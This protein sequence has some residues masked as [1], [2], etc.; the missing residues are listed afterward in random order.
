VKNSG[1]IEKICTALAALKPESLSVEDESHL[2]AGHAGAATGRGHYAVKI[3]SKRFEGKTPIQRH[4]M[5][6]EALGTLMQTDIHAV[7]IQ[8]R[9]SAES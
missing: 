4:R 3:V 9:T 6:Y 1:R 2:H 7:S 5:V 8:A